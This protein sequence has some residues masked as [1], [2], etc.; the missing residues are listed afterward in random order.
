[1]I[2][3]GAACV[4]TCGFSSFFL[5]FRRE[6]GY[7]T[8]LS[9][10]THVEIKEGINEMRAITRIVMTC[11]I[12]CA[13]STVCLGDIIN[14]DFEDGTNGWWVVPTPTGDPSLAYGQTADVGGNNVLELFAKTT[15]T[16]SGNEWL[17]DQS[18]DSNVMVSQGFLSGLYAPAGTTS[19]DFYA[20]ATAVGSSWPSVDV[21]F[22]YTKL[23]G[24]PDS[25]SL[26]ITESGSSWGL[27]TITF[28]EID[29]DE[30]VSIQIRAIADQDLYDNGDGTGVAEVTARFDDFVF[31]P[32]P[33]SLTLLLTGSLGALL[34]KKS[35][36]RIVA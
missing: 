32:E 10:G 22:N 28:N 12:V 17:R 33:C 14:G 18:E 1:M 29:T 7:I 11:L 6:A 21:T 24:D 36:P 13:G 5:A 4:K 20:S 8:T 3:G 15:Y 30:A 16:W 27:R 2:V 34:K 26:P 19:L 35:Y 9:G 25:I 31:I 23:N